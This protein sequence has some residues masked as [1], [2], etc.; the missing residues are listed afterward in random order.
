MYVLGRVG[1]DHADLLVLSA[2]AAPV[3]GLACKDDIGDMLVGELIMHG[4]DCR[5]SGRRLRSRRRRTEG[6]GSA[7]PSP[8]EIRVSQW[9]F[10][11]V[12]LDGFAPL[13]NLHGASR[14]YS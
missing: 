8:L 1:G 6:G 4:S 10:Q 9:H 11:V 5:P 3:F 2:S 13:W 14:V 12:W 7:I